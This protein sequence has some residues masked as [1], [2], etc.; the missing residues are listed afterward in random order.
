MFR[1]TKQGIKNL[2]I[3]FRIIWNDRWWD[4]HYLYDILRFKLGLMEKSFR[5]YGHYVGSEKDAYNMKACC[6]ILDR[7]IADDY[8]D[9][10]FKEH[11]EKWGEIDMKVGPDGKLDITRTN[12]KTAEDEFIERKEFMERCT[13]EGQAETDD[14]IELFKIIARN[15]QKWRD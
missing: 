2:F 3:W 10:A 13:A 5:K 11:D 1:N 12:V 14:V 7:L 8:H 6:D 15:V 9:D 4:H